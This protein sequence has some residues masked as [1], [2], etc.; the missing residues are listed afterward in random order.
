MSS[1]STNK[2]EEAL[3]IVMISIYQFSS[4]YMTRITKQ[5]NVN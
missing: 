2:H 1:P 3:M 5:C 4:Q